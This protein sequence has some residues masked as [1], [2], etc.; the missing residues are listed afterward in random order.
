MALLT[1]P[2]TVDND[3]QPKP[4]SNGNATFNRTVIDGTV[5]GGTEVN[6][7]WG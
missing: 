2:M 4:D 5:V 6:Y 1:N 7:Y 3:G